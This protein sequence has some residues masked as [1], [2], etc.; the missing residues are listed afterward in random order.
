MILLA[1]SGSTK[2]EWILLNHGEEIVHTETIGLNPFFVENGDIEKAILDSTLAPYVSDVESLH[3]FGAGCSN[4]SKAEDL[5][6]SFAQIFKNAKLNIKTDIEGAVHAVSNNEVCIVCILGTGSTFRIFDGQE[7]KR[8]YSSLAYILGDEGSGTHIAKSLIR[9]VFYKE[10]PDD[11]IQDFFKDHPVTV[12]ELLQKVYKEAFANRYLASFVPFCK[13]HI[14]HVEIE[15]IVLSSLEAFFKT[16]L[17]RLDE[18]KSSP[19]H[20]I[21]S[22]AFYFEEQLNMMAEKY[23]ITVGKIVQKPLSEIKKNFLQNGLS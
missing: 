7:V 23:G 4:K 3:F 2:T 15:A 21:G 6:N 5:K 9:K 8:K 20:F 12:E 19:V 13:K 16:H 18:V 10:L 1:D 11:L 22:I 14:D 17:A